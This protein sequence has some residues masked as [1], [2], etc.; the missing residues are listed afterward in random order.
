MRAFVAIDLPDLV[1]GE[2]GD[3]Q[4]ELAVGRAVP[5]ENLHLTLC[6]LG[7]QP[8]EAIKEAHL[9]L[10]CIQSSSFTLRLAGVG[11][12]GKRSPQVIYADVAPSPGLMELEKRI[13]RALR[14]AG[15]RFQKRRFRPHVTVTR[16]PK[17]LSV[18]EIANLQSRLAEVSAFQGSAFE[19]SSFQL[20]QS[21]LTPAGA[22][23]QVLAN[24]EL[25]GS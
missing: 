17:G 2:L 25:A 3:L 24:Y 19:V 11:S 1:R 23:H 18:F 20:Y 4:N 10:S 8:D 22:L 15:L 7:E 5:E 13:T 21:T 14:N 6:F 9:A 12:F 16:L